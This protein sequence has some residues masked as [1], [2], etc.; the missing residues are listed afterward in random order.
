MDSKFIK[1]SVF[2]ADPNLKQAS[3]EW[4][5][6]Y[7]TFS[8]F[9]NSFPAE[10]EI[11]NEDKLKCLIAHISKDVY[12]YVSESL[13]YQEAIQTLERLYLKSCNIFFARHL[14]MTCKQRQAQ[15]LD[16]YFQKLK[17]LAKDCNYR[18]V[19][20]DVCRSKG[21]SDAFI[22]GL[23]STSIRSRLQENTKD[24]SMTLEAIFNQARCFDTAQKSSES[25]T[26]TDGRAI[27]V[28]PVSTIKSC[29]MK[30][31][32]VLPLQVSRTLL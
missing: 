20:A 10:P 22:S 1:P 13:T 3:K 6:W 11:S 25:Y 8:N 2:D 15:S 4:R 27:E 19:S 26:A 7:C 5:H 9:V 14:L 12:D 28:S 17:Q 30:L 16:D 29:E 24:E 23:L 21:I 31:A 32:K 18:S